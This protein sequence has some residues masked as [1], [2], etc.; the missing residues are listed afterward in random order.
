M[1]IDKIIQTIKRKIIDIKFDFEKKKIDE[2]KEK[3]SDFNKNLSNFSNQKVTISKEFQ[4]N[5]ESGDV[6]LV[7][8]ALLDDLIIDRTF[9]TFDED[10]KFASEKLSVLVPYDGEPFETD[11]EKWNKE[12]LNQQKVALMVNFSKERI[13]HLQK[14]IAKVLGP[15]KPTTNE[16]KIPINK[17]T[18]IRL[19]FND[20]FLSNIKDYISSQTLESLTGLDVI[21]S[22]GIEINQNSDFIKE[23][24]SNNIKSPKDYALKTICKDFKVQYEENMSIQNIVESKNKS[25]IIESKYLYKNFNLVEKQFEDINVFYPMISK[26]V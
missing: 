6:M 3:I 2:I 21:D 16:K 12:Y 7:R 13:A 18:E 15:N 5:I 20:I 8:S 4:E 11:P 25:I 22:N 24:K 1:F 26:N 9:K 10:Y 14:V 19:K 23:I 17:D